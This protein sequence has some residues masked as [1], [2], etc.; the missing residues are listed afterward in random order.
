MSAGRWQWHRVL[1][2]LLG[3][4]VLASLWGRHGLIWAAQRSFLKGLARGQIGWLSPPASLAALP[5]TS[6][7]PP[8]GLRCCHGGTWRHVSDEPRHSCPPA[9]VSQWLGTC[10]RVCIYAPEGMG[11]IWALSGH[12]P[13]CYRGKSKGLGLGTHYFS[14]SPSQKC[15]FK[16]CVDQ[17]EKKKKNIFNEKCDEL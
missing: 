6:V 4:G 15:R 14:P 3:R 13:R 12:M 2:A 9:P 8:A 16:Y 11:R 7:G 5:K 10:S 17:F 1:N